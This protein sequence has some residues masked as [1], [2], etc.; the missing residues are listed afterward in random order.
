VGELFI[1]GPQVAFSYLRNPEQ[2]AKAF[3]DNPFRPGSTMYA[4]G[5]LVRVNPVDGSFSYLGRRDTQVKIRGLRVEVGEVES[6]LRATSGAITNAV[7]LKADLGRECLVALLKY[8]SDGS[9]ED[10]KI[11]HDKALGPLLESLRYT[12]RQP[13]PGYMAHN[14]R[15]TQPISCHTFQET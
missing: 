3:I 4:T 2:T 8:Q 11:L 10:I 9:T 12:V 6:V 5:D 14:L 1:G 7:V 13:L 15:R